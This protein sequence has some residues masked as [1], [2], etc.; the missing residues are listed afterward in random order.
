M[1]RKKTD[2][3]MVKKNLILSLEKF[4]KFLIKIA[5]IARIILVSP[6]LLSLRT[7]HLSVPLLISKSKIESLN[8]DTMSNASF[9][10]FKNTMNISSSILY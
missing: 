10:S 5:F 9:N 7:H 2:I 6:F 3:N 1:N 8:I 4:V